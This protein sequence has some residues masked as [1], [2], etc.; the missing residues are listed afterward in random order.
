[1]KRGKELDDV[2]ALDYVPTNATRKW[3]LPIWIAEWRDPMNKQLAHIAYSRGKEW[4]HLKWVPQLEQE[5]RKAW[6]DFCGA[7]TDNE[8]SQEFEKQ[9]TYCQT[10]RGFRDI[11]VQKRSA[12]S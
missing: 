8:Y 5:F 7:I 11:V 2:L 4:N 12:V 1:M 3:E 6:W 10:K 9:L